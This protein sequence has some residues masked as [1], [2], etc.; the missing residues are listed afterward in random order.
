MLEIVIYVV[1]AIVIIALLIR[2]E[3]K[4]LEAEVFQRIKRLGIKALSIIGIIN[5]FTIGSEQL[6]ENNDS[7]DEQETD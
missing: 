1:L 5:I 6:P 7:S 4:K 2:Y 3:F